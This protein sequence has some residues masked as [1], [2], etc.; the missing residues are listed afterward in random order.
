[1]VRIEA[2][3][4]GVAGEVFKATVTE[5][6]LNIPKCKFL[7]SPPAPV[8]WFNLIVDCACL[9]IIADN[10]AVKLVKEGMAAREDLLG[11]AAL[12]ALLDDTN[13]VRLVGVVTVPRD[14]VRSPPSQ[15]PFSNLHR[16]NSVLTAYLSFLFQ[17]VASQSPP[18]STHPF[19]VAEPLS[20]KL[21]LT[22]FVGLSLIRLLINTACRLCLQPALLLM[23]YCENGSVLEFVDG[24]DFESLT[25]MTRLS[26]CHDAA[27]GLEYLEARKVVHRDVAARNLL[28]DAAL[29]CK[30]A[31]LGMSAGA[32]ISSFV[33]FLAVAPQ[34]LCRLLCEIQ[35][36][37]VGPQL[38]ESCVASVLTSVQNS[39]ME[40]RY[41][42]TC[43][44][45]HPALLCSAAHIQ[46]GVCTE[47]RSAQGG[48]APQMG[49]D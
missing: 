11:E 48:H 37:R 40:R 47:L 4:S 15:T 28:L 16:L 46:L 7:Q 49:C 2:L 39:G 27:R 3:G 24:Q 25:T 26:F 1:M 45:T 30:L 10:V 18:R 20:L 23:E 9:D 29:V 32:P 34:T 13:I 42:M 33:L 6:K 12:M 19:V 22:L 41:L 38:H 31:D 5:P 17:Y 35:F 8:T 43:L 21:T 14:M 36:G 44:V